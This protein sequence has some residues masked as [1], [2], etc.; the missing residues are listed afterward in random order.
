MPPLP[1]QKRGGKGRV[2]SYT[3]VAVLVVLI[4]P[5][6][7]VFAFFH[8]LPESNLGE[9]KTRRTGGGSAGGGS[10]RGAA[11][12]SL[13][14][15]QQ[16]Q[17]GQDAPPSRRTLIHNQKGKGRGRGALPRPLSWARELPASL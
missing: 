7:V 13:P 6:L 11:R 15:K 4:A 14:S 3:L 2:L 5:T 16:A 1:Q 9:F 12:R 8:S 10:A 17:E